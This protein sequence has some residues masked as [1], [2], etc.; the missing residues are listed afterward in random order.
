MQPITCINDLRELA[1]RRVPR[2]IFDYIDRGSYDELTLNANRADLDALR[3]RQRVMVDVSS[4]SVTT[5]IAGEPAAM[6]VA[7][8]PTG[9]TGLMHGD[10]EI[11]AARAAQAAGVPFCLSTMSICSIEDVRAAVAQPFW[12]QLYVMKDRGFARSL[13]ARARAAGCSALVL[14]LDLQI[15]GQRH[16]DLKNGLAVPPRLTLAN[17]LDIATKPAWALRVLLGKRRTFGNLAECTGGAGNLK[18][19]AQWIAGQFD[20][21][22][23]WRDVEWVRDAWGG[24]LILK[25]VL[26]A[27]DARLAAASGADAIIV[28]NHGG[29]QLDGAPSAIAA[30]PEIVDAVGHR[31]EVLFDSGVRSGQDVLKAL[32]LGARACLIGKAFLWGLGALGEAGV[33]TTLEIIRRELDVSMALTGLRDVREVTRAVLWQPDRAATEKDFSRRRIAAAQA[34]AS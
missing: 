14:T 26:D 1:L 31:A 16:R 22:L 34:T 20:P 3:L 23:N 24:K 27:E 7:L 19:L 2:A 13:I 25:G 32:A 12:F 5:T 21:S 9:L 28:S 15:Q 30:L 4:R 10:G 8:A 11:L 18:T 6:P 17:A 29:R 33:R